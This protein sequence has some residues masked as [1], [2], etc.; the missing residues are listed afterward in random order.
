M[1]K[2]KKDQRAVRQALFA[3]FMNSI[4]QGK[5]KLISQNQCFKLKSLAFARWLIASRKLK[6]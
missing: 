5:G 2:L 4:R 6:C 3:L 1:F